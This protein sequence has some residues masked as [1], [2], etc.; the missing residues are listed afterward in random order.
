VEDALCVSAKSGVG[1]DV[2]RQRIVNA[3]Q[4]AVPH[5]GDIVLVRDRQRHEAQ[6]AEA[7]L[8]DALQAWRDGAPEEA[9]AS[10]LRRA[11]RA[12]DRMLGTD[13]TH[14]VLNRIFSTFCIGK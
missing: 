1:V 13:V 8:R 4:V 6:T 14:D 5:D 7:A 10:E 9:T 3:A 12:C 11:A 2:L